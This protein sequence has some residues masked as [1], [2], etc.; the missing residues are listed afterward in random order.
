MKNFNVK[1]LAVEM[2]WS[3]TYKVTQEGI[4]NSKNPLLIKINLY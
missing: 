3:K 2:E 4:E 1:S